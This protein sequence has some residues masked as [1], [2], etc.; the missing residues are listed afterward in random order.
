MRS[1]ICDARNIRH[2]IVERDDETEIETLIEAVFTVLTR[3]MQFSGAGLVQSEDLESMR[4]EMTISGARRLVEDIKKW[5]EDAEREN[6]RLT[7]MADD[8]I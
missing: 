6:R 4:F 5:I 8:S 7:L 3:K 2:C 1:L